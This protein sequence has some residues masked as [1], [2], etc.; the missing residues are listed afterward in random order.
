MT[1]KELKKVLGLF[2]DDVD[3]VVII[4][5]PE[6]KQPEVWHVADADADKKTERIILKIE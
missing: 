5:G 1:V 4:P 6:T 3:V 2:A